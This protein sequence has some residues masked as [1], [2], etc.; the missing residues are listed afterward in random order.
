[1]KSK[2]MCTLTLLASGW[3]GFVLANGNVLL[4]QCQD[5]LNVVDGGAGK[6]AFGGGVC[7][8]KIEGTLDGIE[9]ARGY[10]SAS[11]GKTLPPFICPPESVT[12]EQQLRIVVKYLKE[13][14]EKL[15]QHEVTSIAL[16][17]ASAFPCGKP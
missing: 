9:M 17:M 16:A 7:L 3:T 1:M 5:A 6:S 4:Q 12:K 13:N 10:Y 11:S 2:M 15:H 14:P 8:G